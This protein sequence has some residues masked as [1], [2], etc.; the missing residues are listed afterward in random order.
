L[1]LRG[2][3]RVEEAFDGLTVLR[4]DEFG[5]DVPVAERLDGGNPERRFTS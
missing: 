3:E 2:H 4:A 1:S 5:H